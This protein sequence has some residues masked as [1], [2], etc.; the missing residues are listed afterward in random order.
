MY[1]CE[2]IQ[3]LPEQ[4]AFY[5]NISVIYPPIN[6][7]WSNLRC[8]LV[9]FE[10]SFVGAVVAS[11]VT[12]VA[13]ADGCCCCCVLCTSFRKHTYSKK[14]KIC[15]FINMVV[16]FNQIDPNKQYNMKKLKL[17]RCLWKTIYFEHLTSFNYRFLVNF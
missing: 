10:R 14:V 17:F 15:V 12:A 13:V 3:A 1:F 7:L 11:V 5:R 6:L 8:T 9:Y 16:T 2:L 4:C